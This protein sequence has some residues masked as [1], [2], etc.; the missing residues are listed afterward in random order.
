MFSSAEPQYP[1]ESWEGRGPSDEED[2]YWEPS[3][4]EDFEAIQHALEAE[5]ER[6]AANRVVSSR[7]ASLCYHPHTGWFE[8]REGLTWGGAVTRFSR[9]FK[10]QASHGAGL[11]VRRTCVRARPRGRR[12]RRSRRIGARARGPDSSDEGE[13]PGGRRQHVA[14]DPG[15]AR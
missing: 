3:D 5:A 11:R 8:V 2:F 13:P 9:H 7:R 1:D 15:A 14:L 10:R 4:E 12:E 6:Q